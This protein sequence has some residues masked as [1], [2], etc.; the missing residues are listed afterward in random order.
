VH[1]TVNPCPLPFPVHLT[2]A[3]LLAVVSRHGPKVARTLLDDVLNGRREKR[4][5]PTAER[6]AI[7][8]RWH[9]EEGLGPAAIA[10]R[11]EEET[12][13]VVEPNAVKQALHR[14]R[15]SR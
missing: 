11:W 5:R 3:Q 1:G 6:N 10:S 8:K 9:E 14:T 12:G 15:R 7:W 13:D 2:L 4:Q